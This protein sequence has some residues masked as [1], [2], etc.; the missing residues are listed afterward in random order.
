M[1]RYAKTPAE[2]GITDR[3]FGSVSDGSIYNRKVR[4]RRKRERTEVIRV[5]RT[6][7][8][9]YVGRTVEN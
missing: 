4:R 7:A 5:N 2:W 3:Q 1:V 8:P 9:V 6:V